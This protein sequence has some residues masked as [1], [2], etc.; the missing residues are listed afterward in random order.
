MYRFVSF[1][2]RPGPVLQAAFRPQ[3]WLGKMMD[4][5]F[6]PLM[7]WV[8]GC[9]G[10]PQRTH[11]W[12]NQKLSVE[13]VESLDLAWC[14]LGLGDPTAKSRWHGWIPQFHLPRFGGWDKWV[15]IEPVS[16][17][18]ATEWYIGWRSAHLNGVSNVRI[19]G[20][21]RMLRGPEEVAFF[22]I[23]RQGRQI[24]LRRKR[25]GRLGRQHRDNHRYP[26]L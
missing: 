19:S 4:Y 25:Y 9:P 6:W 17:S 11:F 21:V 22:G 14:V 24:P 12:N 10:I 16:R 2:T 15:L 23:D 3:G 13:A 1:G 8:Q 18:E 26:L 7:L 5:L 20:P